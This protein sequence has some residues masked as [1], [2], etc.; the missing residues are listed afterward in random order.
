VPEISSIVYSGSATIIQGDNEAEVTCR[1]TV[2][3]QVVSSSSGHLRRARTRW[4]GHFSCT[5][6]RVDEA[7]GTP[8]FLR[9]PTGETYE[10]ALKNVTSNSSGVTLGEFYG[11]GSPPSE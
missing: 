5:S 3:R 10:I 2:T 9:L 4:S 11:R 1:I 8:A 7:L 6:G